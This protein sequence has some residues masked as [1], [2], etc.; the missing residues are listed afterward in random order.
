M[1]LILKN[2]E[3]INL[4]WNSIVLEYLEEY[5]GGLQQLKIDIDDN[6]CR[7]RVFNYVIYCLISA[8]YPKELSYREAVTL[9]NINDY[10][11]II[12]FIVQNVNNTKLTEFTNI[13]E[14]D[15]QIKS[16]SRKH[17]I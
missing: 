14:T 15:I 4:D 2:G 5:D 13:N 6:A 7:F 1:E 17:R 10:D 9:V 11:K 12:A 16:N 8:A 3:K